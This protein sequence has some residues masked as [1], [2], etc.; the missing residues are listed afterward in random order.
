MQEAVILAVLGFVP[1][2]GITLLVYR[3][4]GEATRLPV[5]MTTNRGI[6]VFGLTVAMCC[7]SA[8]LAL[9]KVRSADPAEIF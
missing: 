6:A 2:I 1:G 8:A 4:A 7:I 3:T 5:E 9:R